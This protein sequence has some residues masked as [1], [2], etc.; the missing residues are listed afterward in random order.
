MYTQAGTPLTSQAGEDSTPHKPAT[1]HRQLKR[2]ES[3]AE[4]LNPPS[5]YL[6]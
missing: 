1:P 2:P 6:P 3:H 4:R 5:P